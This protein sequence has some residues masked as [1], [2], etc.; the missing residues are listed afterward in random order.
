M[1]PFYRSHYK[2]V[3]HITGCLT[4]ILTLG[5]RLQPKLFNPLEKTLYI[6]FCPLDVTRELFHSLNPIHCCF[7]WPKGFKGHSGDRSMRNNHMNPF[8]N[9]FSFETVMFIPLVETCCMYD[10]VL[11]LSSSLVV[12]HH[13]AHSTSLYHFFPHS[14]CHPLPHPQRAD[15]LPWS[16]KNYDNKIFPLRGSQTLKSIINV[17]HMQQN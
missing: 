12:K 16:N 14:S 10:E 2:A 4:H 6:R 17:Q 9:Y 1:C 5:S 11:R 8:F 7:L 15:R 3:C 13:L